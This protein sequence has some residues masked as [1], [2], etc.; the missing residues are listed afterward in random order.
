MRRRATV[1]AAELVKDREF[2]AKVAAGITDEDIT[3]A[4]AGL[5]AAKTM[6]NN[7]ADRLALGGEPALLDALVTEL[8]RKRRTADV[9]CVVLFHLSMLAENRSRIGTHPGVLEALAEASAEP[10]TAL[11]ALGTLQW[12]VNHATV[13]GRFAKL[14]LLRTFY[15]AGQS[16]SDTIRVRGIGSLF[17]MFHS[18]AHCREMTDFRE[19]VAPVAMAATSDS[20]DLVAM[21]A[22]F[23]VANLKGSEQTHSGT[24][25][26]IS[27]KFVRLMVEC[28]RC[29]AEGVSFQGMVWLPMCVFSIRN[30][31]LSS[32]YRPFLATPAMMGILFVYLSKFGKRSNR[33]ITGEVAA[34]AIETLRNI[35]E[36]RESGPILRNMFLG[37]DCGEEIVV[38]EDVQRQFQ[39]LSDNLESREN[40]D[41]GSVDNILEPALMT[42]SKVL[43][44]FRGDWPTGSVLES[45][46]CGF[47][48]EMP[49]KH[50]FV[51]YHWPDQYRAK[52][53]STALRDVYGY[54]VYLRD[55]GSEIV[56]AIATDG[57]VTT[58]R[59]LDVLEAAVLVLICLSEDYHSAKLEEAQL[60]HVVSIHQ[61][62]PMVFVAMDPT[63]SLGVPMSPSFWGSC[64]VFPATS[65]DDALKCADGIV[66]MFR[67]VLKP[68]MLPSQPLASIPID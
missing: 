54:D 26:R 19:E 38:L 6:I 51:S 21:F 24:E 16:P 35:M 42:V 15:Q 29:S 50:I 52:L 32:Y 55:L 67:D 3:T 33:Q 37:A 4:V 18:P 44:G 62:Y 17:N 53:L 11:N 36:G 63:Y 34:L 14:G 40:F 5:N 65:D 68:A 57:R 56:P 46:A 7:D 30:L 20:C 8:T 59:L 25:F 64:P 22:T 23:C 48:S 28:V 12:L 61:L 27:G 66:S 41:G 58:I 43:R 9:A 31:S 39:R 1:G 47:P 13:A 60:A 49:R 2:I 45:S 10:I